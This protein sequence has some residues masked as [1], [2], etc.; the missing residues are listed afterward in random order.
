MKEMKENLK[1]LGNLKITIVTHT[2]KS[3]ENSLFR[4]TE[5][6]TIS[7]QDIL[8]REIIDMRYY[9]IRH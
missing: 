5:T 7:I 4:D 9:L 8:S 1:N 2:K 6:K 3:K